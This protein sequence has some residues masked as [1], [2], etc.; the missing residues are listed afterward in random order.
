MSFILKFEVENNINNIQFNIN[1]INI[2]IYDCD[3]NQFTKKDKNGF[4][5][6]EIPNCYSSCN[7]IYSNCF[8]NTSYSNNE[9]SPKYNVCI[10]KDGF[11]GE[12][13]TKYKFDDLT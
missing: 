7:L 5:L 1:N 4:I 11:E 8:Q 10:C 2:T 3:I 9:N 13:C 12:D 6:C